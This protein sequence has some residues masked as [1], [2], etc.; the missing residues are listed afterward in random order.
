MLSLRR[1]ETRVT[2]VGV[3]MFDWGSIGRLGSL[4][5][6]EPVSFL[7]HFSVMLGL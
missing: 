1:S 2:I 3:K 6:P 5:N 7:N 4:R